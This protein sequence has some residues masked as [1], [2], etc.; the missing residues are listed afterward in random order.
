VGGLWA[1]GWPESFGAFPTPLLVSIS[2]HFCRFRGI[3]APA[4]PSKIDKTPV[5]SK[6]QPASIDE[7]GLIFYISVYDFRYS[8]KNCPV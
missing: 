1:V 6:D 8:F 4:C 5:R 3:R 2:P 7:A